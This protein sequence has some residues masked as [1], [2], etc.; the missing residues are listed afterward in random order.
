MRNFWLLLSVLWLWTCSGGGGSPTEP[1]IP[2]MPIVE[3][4]TVATIEDVPI[5]ISFLGSEPFG[6]AMTYSLTGSPQNGT[7]S[8][9]GS[10]ATY[11]PNENYNGQDTF[12]Y[13][14]TSTTGNSNVG[15]ITVNITPE[16][17][18]P[19]TLDISA[20]TNEDTSIQIELEAEEYDG[21]NIIFN[22]IDNASN[23]NITLASNEVTYMPNQDFFGN[24]SFTYEA[25]DS[26]EKKILNVATA[27]IIVNPINDAPTV[28]DT[29][30]VISDE[31]TQIVLEAIDIENDNISFSISA[32][33][34]NGSAIINGNNLLEFTLNQNSASL[35]SLTVLAYDGTDYSA[36]M[37]VYMNISRNWIVE[38][39]PNIDVQL[40]GGTVDNDGNYIV[41]GFVENTST[42]IYLKYDQSANLILEKNLN[43]DKISNNYWELD[44]ISDGMIISGKKVLS[45]GW[46]DEETVYKLDFDGNVVW[47]QEYMIRDDFRINDIIESDNGYKIFGRSR[48]DSDSGFTDHRIEIIDIDNSGNQLSLT[49]KYFEPAD[50][51][52]VYDAL[53]I[54]DGYIFPLSADQKNGVNSNR[55]QPFIIKMDNENN[56]KAQY[57][58]DTQDENNW[59][60]FYNVV[61]L[62]DGSFFAVGYTQFRGLFALIS[63]DLSS[64]NFFEGSLEFENYNDV[65]LLGNGNVLSVCG[66]CDGDYD[67]RMDDPYNFSLSPL[68]SYKFAPTSD[69]ADVNF[70][71]AEETDDGG[72][73]VVG[74]FATSGHNERG[75]LL[76]KFNALGTPER[77]R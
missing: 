48:I 40:I 66:D 33:P 29:T 74:E 51:L 42:V 71:K 73:F 24:D 18:N 53:K 5:A 21:D 52:F 65:A 57:E 45:G 63:S 44:K 32:P 49:S 16:D 47:Q 70:L 64:G 27:S 19:L 3:N 15:L 38:Y 58:A 39:W 8:V 60:A 13:I 54:N 35:D 50:Y 56:F 46:A 41:L 69:Y 30:V 34:T 76:I 20:T 1:E 6:L 77:I 59:N 17:D 2:K 7:V 43:L 12:G 26:D 68:S 25:V 36:D 55:T 61:E 75:I 23:G 4:I 62:H 22:I 37:K 31:T 9:S 72:A 28:S 67:I 10:A 11:T 14:A